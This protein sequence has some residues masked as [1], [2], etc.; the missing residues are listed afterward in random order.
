MHVVADAQ[1]GDVYAADF[2]RQARGEPLLRMCESRIESLAGWSSRLGGTGLVLGPGLA[3]SSILAAIPAGTAIADPECHRPRAD[4][5]IELARRLW[6]GGQRDD[7]H[8]LEPRYLRRSAAE[9]KWA[10]PASTSAPT[11]P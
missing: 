11:K 6:Q 9:E 4:Q 8:A 3:S 2:A 7:L 1:R 10:A 5:L